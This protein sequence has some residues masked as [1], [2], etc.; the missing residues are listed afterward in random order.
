MSIPL[1]LMVCPPLRRRN[2][3]LGVC[4]VFFVF[5][6]DMNGLNEKTGKILIPCKNGNTVA[7]YPAGCVWFF[8]FY[9][10]HSHKHIL[11]Q[12]PFFFKENRVMRI[13]FRHTC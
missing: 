8:I 9:F 12:T 3:S 7:T 1:H 2:G 13:D 11:I 10:F 5:S 4:M 6:A